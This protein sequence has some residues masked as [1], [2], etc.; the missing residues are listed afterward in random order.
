MRGHVGRTVAW[1][2][3][4][5]GLWVAGAAHTPAAAQSGGAPVE[6]RVAWWGSQDRHNRTIKA[7]ELFQ[8]KYPNIKVTYEFAGWG[9]YWTK[10]TT[11][12]A[13][14]NLPDVM[15]QDYAYVTEWTSRRRLSRAAWWAGS[16]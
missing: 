5:V 1:M 4:I 16:S 8:K 14:R 7:I 13:G 3:V 2:T 10:M 15:Q 6:L 9:D 11:Q 12:A